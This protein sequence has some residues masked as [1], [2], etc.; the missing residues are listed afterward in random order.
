MRCSLSW[1]VLALERAS[2]KYH[3]IIA[4]NMSTSRLLLFLS[5]PRPASK[6]ECA[7]AGVV[8]VFSSTPAHFDSR[9]HHRRLRR[10]AVGRVMAAAPAFC[11]Q[12]TRLNYEFPISAPGNCRRRWCSTLR[13]HTWMASSTTPQPL[14]ELSSLS[15]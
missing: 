10:A 7:I 8:I 6:E 14:L 5:A 9:H 13:A 15:L 11:I 12:S 1:F 3:L 4:P 2:L